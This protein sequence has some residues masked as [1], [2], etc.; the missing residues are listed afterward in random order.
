MPSQSALSSAVAKSVEPVKI[1]KNQRK[2]WRAAGR[3]AWDVRRGV[4]GVGCSVTLV[5]SSTQVPPSPR[6]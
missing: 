1:F 4:W 6:T 3:R 5:P 2:M